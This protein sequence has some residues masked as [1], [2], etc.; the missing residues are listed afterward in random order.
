[1]LVTAAAL[2]LGANDLVAQAVLKPDAPLSPEKQV[3]NDAIYR[4]RDSLT[5]IDAAGSRFARDRA[6]AS[7]ASLQSRARLMSERCRS[8][9]TTADSS[10]SVVTAGGLPAPD[11]RGHL[12]RF[13]KAV[14]ELRAKLVW[15]DGEFTRLS[16]PANAAELRGYGIGRAAQVSISVQ[17]YVAAA[18]LYL[19]TA[20]GVRYKPSIQ[21]AGS[22]ASGKAKAS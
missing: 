20:L 5:L 7:D 22:V 18:S 1:M 13:D 16:K 4:L 12:P 11:P 8:A 21:G 6:K 9:V 10:R 2:L 3:I 14:V 19:K 15:C 17:D